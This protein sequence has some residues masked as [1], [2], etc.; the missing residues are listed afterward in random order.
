[1]PLLTHIRKYVDI[2]GDIAYNQGF[3]DGPDTVYPLGFD[4]EQLKPLPVKTY[5]RLHSHKR[6]S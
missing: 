4:T 1:M 2:Q 6:A 3:E 5:I